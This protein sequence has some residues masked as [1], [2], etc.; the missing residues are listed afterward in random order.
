MA[1]NLNWTVW[2]FLA[3]LTFSRCGL[4]MFDLAERQIMQENVAEEQR[5]LINST[6][7][8]L[9]NLFLL[10]SYALGMIASQPY[11]SQLLALLQ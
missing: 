10:I 5:G 6:E 2:P 3:F 8:A 9:S 4:W 1:E 11:L 7:L